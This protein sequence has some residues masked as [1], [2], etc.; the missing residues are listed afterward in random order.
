[1]LHCKVKWLKHIFLF[2]FSCFPE[3]K[4]LISVILQKSL[5]WIYNFGTKNNDVIIKKLFDY[6]DCLA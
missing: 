2:L 3:L 5:Y 6:L 1:V 4:E